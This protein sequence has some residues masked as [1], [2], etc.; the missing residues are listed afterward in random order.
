[1]RFAQGV[2]GLSLGLWKKGFDATGI[3]WQGNRHNTRIPLV[4]R[5][6]TDP[7]QQKEVEE[8]RESADAIHMARRVVLLPQPGDF[9]SV[10]RTRPKGY[11]NRN[12]SGPYRSLGERI[13]SVHTTK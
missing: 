8:I 4:M 2:G 9:P 5:D 10:R 6:L 11:P 1:M 12:P 13:T 7:Q 3:D